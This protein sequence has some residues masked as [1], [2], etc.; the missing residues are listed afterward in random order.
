AA[1]NAVDYIAALRQA[2]DLS[3]LPIG[4]RI[5]VIGGGMTAVDMAVQA[6]LLG[7]EEVTICYRRGKENM[8]ASQYE[9][10]LA[11]ATGVVVRHWVSP[12]SVLTEG[13]TVTGIEL[14]YTT[15]EDGL[16]VGTG[17]VFT[18]PADQVFKAIG[19]TFVGAT[20]NGIG[21]DIPLEGGRIR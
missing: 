11:A 5:V 20:L 9:Q 6:K 16:L 17:E 3:V 14:E 18:L 8:N 15:L 13:G 12:K 21:A 4:R 1:A 7:A 19:Q 2:R 10:D